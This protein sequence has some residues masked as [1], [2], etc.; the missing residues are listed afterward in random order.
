MIIFKIITKKNSFNNISKIILLLLLIFVSVIILQYQQSTVASALPTSTR[1]KNNNDNET[2]IRDESD[3]I[4]E[5]YIED[6]SINFQVVGDW[7][8][9]GKTAD[10]TFYGENQ[11][12][13]A[14]HLEKYA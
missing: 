3:D 8:Y 6:D 4:Y 7:G 5:D 1:G 12:K 11:L 13:V 14:R 9:Q 2:K 10:N